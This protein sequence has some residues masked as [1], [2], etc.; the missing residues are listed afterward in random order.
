MNALIDSI[1]KS[2]SDK[3]DE[4]KEMR[5]EVERIVQT[6]S[7]LLNLE[8]DNVL[9]SLERN[10]DK[11][12][13]RYYSDASYPSKTDDIIVFENEEDLE[14][15][16]Q[17][18]KGFRC[19]HCKGVSKHPYICDTGIKLVLMNSNGKKKPCNWKAFGLFGTLG[20]GMTFTIK[21]GWLKDKPFIDDSF[22]PIAMEK[23]E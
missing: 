9:A 22:M 13:S 17:P 8:P 5:L 18:E 12:P 20:K 19:P 2:Y 16:A 7:K 14:K 11:P 10:R 23:K 3:E 21:D 1:A 6:Y 4:Q 15:R